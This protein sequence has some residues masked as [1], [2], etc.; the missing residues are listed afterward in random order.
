VNIDPNPDRAPWIDHDW[1]VCDLPCGDARYDSVVSSHVLPAVQDLF[2]AMYEM[3]R[4]LKPG[5][6]MAHVIPNWSVAPKRCSRRFPWQYQHQG[7]Y[8]ADQFAEY[9]EKLSDVFAVELCEDFPDFNF[10]FRVRAVRL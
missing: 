7:W 6:H 3:G 4:V 9:M 8:S 5:G 10:S 1:D 2:G